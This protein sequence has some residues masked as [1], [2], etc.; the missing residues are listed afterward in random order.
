LRL[1]RKKIS[2]IQRIRFLINGIKCMAMV[3]IPSYSYD[4]DEWSIEYLT[5]RERIDMF[6]SELETAILG[7]VYILEDTFS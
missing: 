6:K 1:R 3:Y 7:Y 5:F 2:I 4:T